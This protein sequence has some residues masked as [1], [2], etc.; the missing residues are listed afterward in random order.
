V[1]FDSRGVEKRQ[2]ASDSD[3]P[4]SVKEA[5][6]SLRPDAFTW[7][8][9]GL[10]VGPTTLLLFAAFALALSGPE[11]LSGFAGLGAVFILLLS[12]PLLVT[13]YLAILRGNLRASGIISN[14]F[15]YSLILSVVGW[16]FN[17]VEALH[18]RIPP[19]ARSVSLGESAILTAFV[20]YMVVVSFGH[21]RWH[22][23]IK[24]EAT[25]YGKKS[26]IDE[27]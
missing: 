23:R 7:V 27:L 19:N 10:L 6:S 21:L 12:V 25:K 26:V 8:C 3:E 22:R 2:N 4:G 9:V 24:S 1:K 17:L 20:V 5:R 16:F 13:E 14:F 11:G 18:P 15:L